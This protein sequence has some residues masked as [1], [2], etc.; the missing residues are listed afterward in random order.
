MKRGE[1]YVVDLG[2][3]IGTEAYGAC[4]VVVVSSDAFNVAPRFVTVVPAVDSA[5]LTARLG[6]LVV[7]TESGYS[8]DV[9][10]L[11]RQP[12]TLDPSRFLAQPVGFVPATLMAQIEADLKLQLDLK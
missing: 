4:P 8:A 9:A 7:R 10:V 5:A 2:P 12:M 1:I 11:A 3:G 6:V